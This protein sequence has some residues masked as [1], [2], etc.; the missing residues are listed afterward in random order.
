MSMMISLRWIS[1]NEV[2]GFIL[3]DFKTA[4]KVQ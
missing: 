3:S 1:R 4:L 2:G